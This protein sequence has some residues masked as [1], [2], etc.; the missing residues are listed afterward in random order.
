MPDD[1]VK[2]L[3][4][5]TVQASISQLKKSGLLKDT[6]NV[7]YSDASILIASFYDSGEKDHNLAY[8]IAGLRFDPYYK[9]IPLYFKEKKT[10]EAIAEEL[11]VD[12]TT[13][14]R[15]KKRLCLSIYNEII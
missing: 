8:A 10:V 9:I 11:E 13:V 7:A 14:F 1:Q 12:I 6:E 2:K 5:M 3:I 15:N 4:E